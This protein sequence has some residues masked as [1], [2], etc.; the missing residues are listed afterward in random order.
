MESE[1][2]DFILVA[3]DLITT[4]PAAYAG[5]RRDYGWSPRIAEMMRKITA[6]CKVFYLDGNHEIYLKESLDNAYL[7][8]YKRYKTEIQEA[9][10]QV[11]HNESMRIDGQVIL[12]GHEFS[13]E[14]YLRCGRVDVSAGEIV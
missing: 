12:Y 3:G 9:G 14:Y 10:V 8:I 7:P 11:L 13:Y 2:P 6:V 5:V 4:Y 1:R